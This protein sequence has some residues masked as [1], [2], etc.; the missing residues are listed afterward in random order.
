MLNIPFPVNFSCINSSSIA[1]D[2]SIAKSQK[3]GV[4]NPKKIDKAKIKSTPKK[5]FGLS[6][7]NDNKH[8]K[9]IEE[10]IVELC[11]S[12]FISI[13]KRKAETTEAE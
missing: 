12:F 8:P 7:L 3:I 9:I 1:V 6:T 4:E 13:Q 5:R 2:V 11:G 10:T